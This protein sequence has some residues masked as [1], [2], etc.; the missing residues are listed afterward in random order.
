MPP[1]GVQ[2]TTL[3]LY[4]VV[5]RIDDERLLIPQF[6]RGW[7]WDEDRPVLLFDSL[8]TGVFI[9]SIVIGPPTFDLTVR[10]VDSRPR[11]GQGSGRRLREWVV[12]EQEFITSRQNGVDKALVLDGQQRITSIFRLLRGIEPVYFNV[13]KDLDI[14]NI[15]N[16]AF[17]L[18]ESVSRTTD[19]NGFYIPLNLVY[20]LRS[21]IRARK[22]EHYR[23]HLETLH[24]YNSKTPGEQTILLDITEHVGD[25][26]DRFFSDATVSRQTQQHYP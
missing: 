10:E 20:S 9:G 22:L 26:I 24:Y 5:A 1:T 18:M 19:D 15:P 25:I 8:F 23:R 3:S 11:S 13:K 17:D 6:Q 14:G 21:E 4:D 12:T 2:S 16:T 7:E